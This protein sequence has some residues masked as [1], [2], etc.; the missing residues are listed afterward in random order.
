MTKMLFLLLLTMSATAS[1]DTVFEVVGFQCNQAK[2]NIIITH[3][4][5]YNE[6]GQSLVDNMKSNQWDL[7]TLFENHKTVHKQCDLSDGKYTVTISIYSKGSCH[8]CPGFWVKASKDAKIVFDKGLDGYTP[9]DG[10]SNVI[11]KAVIKSR[12][13]KPE[14]TTTT[15]RGFAGF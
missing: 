7:W 13:E 12:D 5:A 2:D 14:L 1:A 4:G 11:T 8:A 15:W 10:A 9:N 3:D 6:K